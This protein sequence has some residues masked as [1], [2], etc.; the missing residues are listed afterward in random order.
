MK[1]PI[2]IFL[3]IG[4]LSVFVLN[5]CGGGGGNNNGTTFELVIPNTYTAADFT[6]KKTIPAGKPIKVYAINEENYETWDE[7]GEF[8]A[9]LQ[10]AGVTKSGGTTINWQIDDEYIGEKYLIG[11]AIILDTTNYGDFELEELM[12]PD[13][14][15]DGKDIIVKGTVN[16]QDD[17]DTTILTPGG[18]TLTFEFIDFRE[19]D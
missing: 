16:Q 15:L 18:R 17:S 3:T 8:K 14:D 5:G 12:S 19:P 1:K 13:L 9:D 7:G 6:T 4:L 10:C 11:A 2:L